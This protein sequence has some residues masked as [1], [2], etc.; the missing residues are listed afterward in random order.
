[1]RWFFELRGT[2][3]TKI[4][5]KAVHSLRIDRGKVYPALLYFKLRNEV[6]PV[7]RG[8]QACTNNDLICS[9][10]VVIIGHRYGVCT[11]GQCRDGLCLRTGVPEVSS[12]GITGIQ[13]QWRIGADNGI[14]ADI[15]L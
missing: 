8:F 5:V 3:V 11:A 10:T 6:E 13:C 4:P 15:H 14:V 9:G 2:T 1:M 12:P 7:G